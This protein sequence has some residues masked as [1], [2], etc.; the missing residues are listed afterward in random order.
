MKRILF[1]LLASIA[2]PNS[3]NAEISDE[4]HKKCLDAKDYAGCVETNK[5]PPRQKDKKISGIGIRFFS[6]VILRN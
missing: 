4:L 3:T 5:K 1:T 6:I 2:L